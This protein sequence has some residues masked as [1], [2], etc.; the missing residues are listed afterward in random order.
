MTIN[1]NKGDKFEY[2][3]IRNKMIKDSEL[4]ELEYTF[5]GEGFE[6]DGDDIITDED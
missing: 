3:K 5:L 2:Q 4:F 6:L 1:L